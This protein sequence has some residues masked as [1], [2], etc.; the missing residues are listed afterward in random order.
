MS[1]EKYF[2]QENLGQQKG[3]ISGI[4]DDTRGVENTL[5]NVTKSGAGPEQP[6][7]GI[8]LQ[9]FQLT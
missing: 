3:V 6:G 4:V 5:Q 8:S 2:R 7:V 9:Y 1:E